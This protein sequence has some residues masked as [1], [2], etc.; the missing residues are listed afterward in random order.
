MSSVEEPTQGQVNYF[1]TAPFTES[2][3]AID[4]LPARSAFGVLESIVAALSFGVVQ[5]CEFLMSTEV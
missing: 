2:K 1:V 4:T 5:C 3:D